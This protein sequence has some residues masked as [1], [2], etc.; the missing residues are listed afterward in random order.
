MTDKPSLADELRHIDFILM[1]IGFQETSRER[2]QIRR[3]LAVVE[4][5]ERMPGEVSGD[6]PRQVWEW[7]AC[8]RELVR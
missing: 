5:V 2:K 7:A 6:V 4:Q 3:A 8:L 1:G